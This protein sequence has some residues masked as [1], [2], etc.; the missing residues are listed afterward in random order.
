MSNLCYTISS[1]LSGLALLAWKRSRV[2]HH[3]QAGNN[4]TTKTTSETHLLDLIYSL[5]KKSLVKVSFDKLKGLFLAAW[6]SKKKY[7]RNRNSGGDNLEDSSAYDEYFSE[8]QKPQ[9]PS[10]D[11]VTSLPAA[12]HTRISSLLI[13]ALVASEWSGNGKIV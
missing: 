1:L 8:G 5:S 10:A 3:H 12:R 4:N 6:N 9:P 11:I 2:L 13:L 7:V